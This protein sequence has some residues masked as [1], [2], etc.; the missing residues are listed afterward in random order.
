[1]RW[2][3]AEYRQRH[4]TFSATAEIGTNLYVC[5][6]IKSFQWT[7]EC[8]CL[9]F[10]RFVKLSS[11][12]KNQAVVHRTLT[13]YLELPSRFSS[14]FCRKGE[15]VFDACVFA[16]FAVHVILRHLEQSDIWNLLKTI[17]S[18]SGPLAKKTNFLSVKMEK[19]NSIDNVYLYGQ[20]W[21]ENGVLTAIV[22]RGFFNQ[23]AW[24]SALKVTWYST[25]G[26]SELK[27]QLVMSTCTK[28]IRFLGPIF[29]LFRYRKETSCFILTSL[30]SKWK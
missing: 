22:S 5:C 12:Y 16:L 20:C 28:P 26:G 29:N 7:K 3:E 18:L 24:Q 4:N 30:W 23:M 14:W 8:S 17:T 10:P 9:S 15:G 25:I 11:Q 13:R 21:W 6:I 2:A 27:R 1:M 19:K